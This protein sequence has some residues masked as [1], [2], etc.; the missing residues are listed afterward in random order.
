MRI[1]TLFEHNRLSDILKIDGMQVELTKRANNVAQAPYEELSAIIDCIECTL[2]N[3][4]SLKPYAEALNKTNV[5]RILEALFF[6]VT[7]ALWITRY[8]QEFGQG[9]QDFVGIFEAVFGFCPPTHMK[10]NSLVKKL[11]QYAKDYKNKLNSEKY[12][13]TSNQYT[14]NQLSIV[15]NIITF[16]I[17]EK[18]VSFCLSGHKNLINAGNVL[19]T[20][21]TIR[22]G[23]Q[24]QSAEIIKKGIKMVGPKA[25]ASLI[26]NFFSDEAK[27]FFGEIIPKRTI[28]IHEKFYPRKVIKEYFSNTRH[29]Y[30]IDVLGCMEEKIHDI[31]EQLI[32]SS[33]QEL[34]SEMNEWVLF[35]NGL[36]GAH[37]YTLHFYGDPM[38]VEECKQY[39][40]VIAETKIISGQ[41]FARELYSINLCF[42]KGI[43]ILYDKL[44]LK[45]TSITEL[46][47]V[48]VNAL[49][50]YLAQKSGYKLITQRR[51]LIYIRALF[52]F[53][54]CTRATC[55]ED[56]FDGF[57]MPKA[58]KNLTIPTARDIL[59]EIAKKSSVLP[60]EVSL[61]FLTACSVGA[62][63]ES[64]CGLTVDDLY[65]EDDGYKLKVHYNKTAVRNRINGK[66]D[67]VIHK[68]ENELADKLMTYIKSTEDLR[69]KLN[70]PY[71]FVYDT[72][73]YRG[74]T[75]RQP[76]ILTAHRFRDEMSKMIKALN[77]Y[78]HDGYLVPCSF[79]NIRAEVGRALFSDGASESDVAGK[80]G[81][82]PTVAR[83]HYHFEYPEEE[84][85][86]YNKQYEMIENTVRREI[87]EKGASIAELPEK[88][89]VLYGY[90]TRGNCNNKNDCSTCPQR[91]VCTG[92][93]NGDKLL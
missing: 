74:D 15:G 39:L 83:K 5:L 50:A 16:E 64:I 93:V 10:E 76:R 47:S 56:P 92:Q 14:I 85:N 18:E 63:A 62:R 66:P 40:R 23:F 52:D 21:N 91:I 53:I 12:H 75:H 87:E 77:I 46:R 2:Q 31:D 33:K 58:K 49:N 72:P 84:A 86:R 59:V 29:P 27:V 48:I 4:E 6:D 78:D 54:S 71:I 65:N 82:S 1:I 68:L 22:E 36:N 45:I 13:I 57:K 67:W 35:Q 43:E 81:N 51:I 89:T 28:L 7:Y 90:C 9:T 61:A 70:Q 60:E 44:G 41:P 26:E 69:A 80:L 79:R 11:R 20:L 24:T 34:Y 19:L 37:Q 73:N 8:P 38:L 17:N 88:H 55:E 3:G 32:E 42:L 25:A 30:I